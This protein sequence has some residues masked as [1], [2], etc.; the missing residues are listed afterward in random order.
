MSAE[1]NYTEIFQMFMSGV[2]TLGLYILNSMRA[3]LKKTG[4]RLSCHLEN[5]GLHTVCGKEHEA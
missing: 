2:G 1:S 5:R 4:E 3:D